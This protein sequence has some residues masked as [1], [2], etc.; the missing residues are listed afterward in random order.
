LPSCQCNT[1]E[2]RRDLISRDETLS[3]VPLFQSLQHQFISPVL[4]TGN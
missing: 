3:V 2:K 4:T 1:L